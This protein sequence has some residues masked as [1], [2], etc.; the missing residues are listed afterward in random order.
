MPKYMLGGTSYKATKDITLYAI[1]DE[2]TAQITFNANGG[3]GNMEPINVSAGHSTKLTKN[4][5]IKEGWSFKKWN[6]EQDGK[7]TA[8][9]NEETISSITEDITL[10]AMWE[11]DINI[12]LSITKNKIVED[13]KMSISATATTGVQNVELKVGANKLYIEN[14]EVSTKEYSKNNLTVSDLDKTAFLNLPFYKINLEMMVVTVAGSK[15]TKAVECTNY[16]IGNTVAWNTFANLVNN[17]N[18]TFS[19]ETISLVNDL[20]MPW[21]WKC[22]GYMN[23]VDTE[24]PYFSGVFNRK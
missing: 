16:T 2:Y 19:G 3:E 23:D 12:V 6:T 1:W 9:G 17:Q 18:M 10:Y 22:C 4:T 24:G 14:L 8:Y 20:N 13:T 5:Y 21:D 11:E 7:G 15:K